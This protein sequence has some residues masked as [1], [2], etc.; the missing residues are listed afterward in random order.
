VC[1]T[2]GIAIQTPNISR[3]CGVCGTLS[4]KV[5]ELIKLVPDEADE[6]R[7]YSSEVCG[8]CGGKFID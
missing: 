5:D 1:G 2:T 8:R 3:A 7:R 4:M 6:I